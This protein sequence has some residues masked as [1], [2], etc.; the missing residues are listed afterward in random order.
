MERSHRPRQFILLSG[1]I[2]IACTLISESQ[3]QV[4]EDNAHIAFHR[5]G[6]SSATRYRDSTGGDFIRCVSTSFEAGGPGCR[7]IYEQTTDTRQRCFAE[8]T[9]SEVKIVGWRM[10][11]DATTTRMWDLRSPGNVARY[12]GDYVIITKYACCSATDVMT[13]FNL[14]TGEKLFSTSSTIA[15]VTL[16]PS[17][18]TKR[19]IGFH[20][21]NGVVPYGEVGDE[22]DDIGILYYADEHHILQSVLFAQNID[23]MEEVGTPDILLIH[24]GD[25]T[26]SRHLSLPIDNGSTSGKLA[27]GFEIMIRFWEGMEIIIP[28]DDDRL[29]ID[30]A[31]IPKNIELIQLT[32]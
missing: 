15:T 21:R 28:V 26:Q 16:M 18:V 2:L 24:K 4:T 32:P 7:Y 9:E 25:T 19:M 31:S 3:A 22:F 12:V 1:L 17:P 8:G 29:R 10:D 5:E 27:S 14:T 30:R 20:T 23:F 6:V 11:D 13:Y